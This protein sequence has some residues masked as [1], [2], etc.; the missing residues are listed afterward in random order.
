MGAPNKRSVYLRRQGEIFERNVIVYIH[1]THNQDWEFCAPV[2]QLDFHHYSIDR[3]ISENCPDIFENYET[4]ATEVRKQFAQAIR[5]KTQLDYEHTNRELD[6]L[7]EEILEQLKSDETICL[8]Y[9]G[10]DLKELAMKHARQRMAK[11]KVYFF[12]PSYLS[13][14]DKLIQIFID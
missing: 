14:Q 11:K 9:Y 3:Y 7:A 13:K 12:W 1:E 5:R 8:F 10:D 6:K 2:L 4:I